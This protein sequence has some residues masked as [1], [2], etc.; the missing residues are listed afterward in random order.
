MKR[1]LKIIC[2]AVCIAMAF[3]SSVGAVS[4]IAEKDRPLLKIEMLSDT[5]IGAEGAEEF[6]INALDGISN[7]AQKADGLIIAGDLS[8]N[9]T[10]ENVARFYGILKEHNKIENVVTAA[11]N[12]DMGQMTYKG[13]ETRPRMIDYRNGY[14][15]DKGDKIYYSTE[16]NGFKFI[17]LGDEGENINC[18]TVSDEQIDFLA[19]ELEEGSKNGAPVFVICHWP[20]AF[21]NGSW[22][23]WPI[24]PG[25]NIGAV[26]TAKIRKIMNA[27]DNVFFISGHLHMGLNNNP[28]QTMLSL[29]TFENHGNTT[30]I[31]LPSVGKT[32]R[33]GVKDRGTGMEIKVYADRVEFLGR[34]Y[35]TGEYYEQC[36]YSERLVEFAPE[37]LPAR[38]FETVIEKK[39]Q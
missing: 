37:L 32:G 29:A 26:T 28:V 13:S 7:D 10:E 11:G 8:N 15:G 23:L 25:G 33:F 9:G 17:V 38:L 16:I 1:I 22:L 36:T 35:V 34:N 4:F 14:I 5:H 31:N 27:Y 39:E 2:I 3:A 6:V 30:F 20:P 19:K 18:I 21:I 12:H 24:W